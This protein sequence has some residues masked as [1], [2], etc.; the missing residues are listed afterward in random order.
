[1]RASSRSCSAV[2]RA[3]LILA[4]ILSPALAFADLYCVSTATQLSNAITAANASAA[5]S[6]IRVKTGSYTFASTPTSYALTV[7]GPSDLLLTGGWT[8]TN[9][10]T[11]STLNP[12]VTV[13][14]TGGTGK[15]MYLK[16]PIFPSVSAN[17]V[18]ISGLSFRNAVSAD[19]HAACLFVERPI[20][21][22][23]D[24]GT[25][26]LDRNSFRL[27]NNTLDSSTASALKIDES[28]MN[29][30]VRN[31][32]F[33]DNA[34]HDAIAR[35]IGRNN[36]VHHVTNN[37]LAYNPALSATASMSGLYVTGVDS[38]T[39]FWVI[40]NVGW[41]NGAN[42]PDGSDLYTGGTAVGVVSS[43]IF[44]RTSSP[45]GGISYISNLNSNPLFINSN[46]LRPGKNSPMRNSGAF[47]V[48]GALD[49]DLLGSPRVQGTRIDRGAHETEELLANGFE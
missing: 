15:L 32:V 6:E 36:S 37:T 27:C 43:N 30:Y 21:A 49:F 48:G 7:D 31:N 46:D 5:A 17:T 42:S 25:L 39:F 47:P 11:R 40:N 34:G 10:D 18:E 45:S 29:I 8:G 12:E 16:F 4:G 22:N 26:Y 44:G 38:S 35:L 1:M 33:V 24:R 28:N 19:L 9:C 14:T 2:L 3:G 23:S 20:I 41:N 13:L